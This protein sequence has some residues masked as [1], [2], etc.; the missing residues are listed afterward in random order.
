[1]GFITACLCFHILGIFPITIFHILQNDKTKC[2]SYSFF[3]MPILQF[4][5]RTD[6]FRTSIVYF[7]YYFLLELWTSQYRNFYYHFLFCTGLNQLICQ[8]NVNTLLTF[9]IYLGLHDYKRYKNYTHHLHVSRKAWHFLLSHSLSHSFFLS[10][11]TQYVF[12]IR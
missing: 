12:L 5:H 8:Q 3:I 2:I 1:M 10:C 7:S 6:I 11:K 4:V 9:S